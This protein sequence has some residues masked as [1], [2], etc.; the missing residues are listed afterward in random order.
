MINEGNFDIKTKTNRFIFLKTCKVGVILLST[1]LG[2]SGF[3][4]F[5]DQSI[6]EGIGFNE[7]RRKTGGRL[8][9]LSAISFCGAWIGI[10][11]REAAKRMSRRSG[12]LRRRMKL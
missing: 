12:P 10:S 5:N 2:V 7:K 6:K 1:V 9:R 3:I 11:R 4:C 8:F